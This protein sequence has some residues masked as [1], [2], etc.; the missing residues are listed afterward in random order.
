MAIS[1]ME[2][3]DLTL[4]SEHDSWQS[5]P[6]WF[7]SRMEAMKYY[8]GLPSNPKLVYRTGPTRWGYPTG[9][10]AY[11]VYKELRPVFGHNICTAWKD[12]GPKVCEALDS[13]EVM[14]TS[15]DM[16]RSIWLKTMDDDIHNPI[17]LWIGVF[18]ES[19]AG[20]D[21]YAAGKA[22]LTLLKEFGITD[23]DVEFRESVYTR[24]AGVGPNL[25]APGVDPGFNLTE[26]V[27]GPLTTA[28]GLGI[29]PQ[30]N[31]QVEGTGGLYLAEGGE[32][33]KVLLV[34]A[35]HVLFPPNGP[36][37]DYTY[38]DSNKPPRR[39]I[40]LLG[41]KAFDKLIRSIR[42]R[43]HNHAT[44][45][46]HLGRQIEYYQEKID[47][48]QDK[49]KD[50][51]AD[52]EGTVVA[53][54]KKRKAG[55]ERYQQELDD[56]N[57]VISALKDFH[58][59]VKKD[60][61]RKSQRVLGHVVRSPPLTFGA[62]PEGFT[63]DYALIEL[64]STRFEGAFEGNKLHI[65]MHFLL[66]RAPVPEPDCVVQIRISTGS[67]SLR[68]CR[69]AGWKTD[70]TALCTAHMTAFSSFRASSPKGKWPN[71]TP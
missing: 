57:R 52:D 5:Q 8:A 7:V 15:I 12:L 60:W 25:L 14:W 19:L 1:E 36:N 51:G 43:I 46:Q 28:L 58:D 31:P 23:V 65:G 22:C 2:G 24:T 13:A 63:E 29:A 61:H 17:A 67:L 37:V 59:E 3:Q 47:A 62:G 30:I 44:Q 21:A 68:R 16:V 38:T 70:S 20:K 64:D 48:R 42:I 56:A 66:F 10:E 49:S 54:I 41:R 4:Y 18:P 27:C 34:T 6:P 45:A 71:P 69:P 55:L 53:E 50:Y 11:T 32:S 9:P 33:K 39:N 26:D 35:R 40:L